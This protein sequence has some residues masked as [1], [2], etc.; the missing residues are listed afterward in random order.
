MDKF[1]IVEFAFKEIKTE[2][3]IFQIIL[4]CQ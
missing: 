3:V 1:E 2:T 4:G